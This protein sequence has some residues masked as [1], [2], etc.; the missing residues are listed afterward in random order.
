MYSFGHISTERF[1]VLGGEIR[2]LCEGVE[3]WVTDPWG[4]TKVVKLQSKREMRVHV[5]RC[6]RQGGL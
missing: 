6:S 1:S 3:M 5:S 4:F 2:F